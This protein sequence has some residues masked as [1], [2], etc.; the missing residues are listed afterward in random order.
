M[1]DSSVHERGFGFSL[2]FVGKKRT[3]FF[4]PPKKKKQSAGKHGQLTA[5]VA[6]RAGERRS[7]ALGPHGEASQVPEQVAGRAGER[8][9]GAHR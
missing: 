6:G 7:G 5:Q 2:L 9:N 1:G 8:R 4:W 3:Y